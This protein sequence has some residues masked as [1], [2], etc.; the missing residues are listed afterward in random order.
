MNSKHILSQ[1][2]DSTLYKLYHPDTISYY[3][4]LY[5]DSTFNDLEY[6]L[7]SIFDVNNNKIDT[8][9]TYPNSAFSIPDSSF[10]SNAQDDV[11]KI[12]K[13]NKKKSFLEN[14]IKNQSSDS[15]VNDLINK[16]I[17][18]YNN[19]VIDY[20]NL[21]IESG[22]AEID[23]NEMTLFTR[24]YYDDEGKLVQKP[25]FKD[26]DQE[27][28]AETI[29]YNFDTGKGY[30]T[31]IITQQ[32]DGFLHGEQVKLLEDDITLIRHGGYTTC[33]QEHPHFQFKFNK[34]K[35]IP[36]DKI[37]SGLTYLE[38][39]GI[40]TPLGLP[41]AIFPIIEGGTS[42]IVVPGYGN[43]ADRGFFLENG[44]YYWYIN[45][46]IDLKLVGDIYSRGSWAIKPSIN[47]NKRYKYK[48]NFSFSY[49]NNKL[50]I[51][52]TKDFTSRNDFKITWKHNQD[53]K[54][55]PNNNFSAD[56]NFFTSSYNKYNPATTTDY[57]SS[58]F[59]SS[60][61]YQT[62][63]L[64]NKVNL[65]INL[66]HSQNTKTRSMTFTLPEFSLSVAKLYPFK[67]KVQVGNTRWYEKI[68]FNYSMAGKNEITSIDTLLLT[69]P[70][71][72]KMKNGIKHTLNASFNTNILKVLNFSVSANYN[73]RWYSKYAN[74]YY[75]QDTVYV[76]GEAI[77]PQLIVEELYKFKAARDFNFS[78][79]IGTTLYGMVQFKKGFL[80]AVRHVFTPS[81]SF[82]YTPD[83]GT[84]F[85][86]NYDYY[87][88]KNGDSVKYSIYNVSSFSSLY[89]SPSD[90]TSGR[91]NFALGNNLE[92]KVRSKNDTIT[93]TKKI[94]LIENLTISTYYDFAKDSLRLA[95][96]T[97]SGRT[98]IIK[99]L[100]IS[101]STQLSPYK[102]NEDGVTINEFIWKTEKRLFAPPSQSWN[103]GFSYTLN[104]N[105]FKKKNNNS[106]QQ[107]NDSPPEIDPIFY[108]SF[109]YIDWD[110]P[111]SISLNYNFRYEIRNIMV[112]GEYEKQTTL[113]NAIS[114]TG[115][116]NITPKWKISYNLTY[117]LKA[118]ELTY[119][120]LSIYRDLHCWEMSFNW[121]PFGGQKSWSFTINVKSSMLNSLKYEMKSE[122]YRNY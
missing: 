62:S 17:Y 121:I 13:Q 84:P 57:L 58:T 86:G 25:K 3:K 5:P 42:G 69:E 29:K 72:D 67:R 60:I 61:A 104:Q 27:F 79:S 109:E 90:G 19:F 18:Y 48:G 46:R 80:R 110:N 112:N 4:S 35:V 88:D 98:S 120:K 59:K 8:L 76:D 65:A 9:I 102:V 43:S 50:G 7:D 38:I 47:Y 85:W 44:G 66:G 15:M 113:V 105:T 10:L 114:C 115:N 116:V 23:M 83:F 21:H 20:G 97:I 26:G 117:D 53:A 51:K 40:P 77:P 2:I 118:L 103:L 37:V 78:T 12:I 45:D 89:G 56:V 107:Q 95:P 96:L 99:G 24:G 36:D 14:I 119:A 30:V 41:F 64:K 34:G 100:N 16:K 31:N 101:Y 32:G 22:Y 82:T 73:E 75:Q 111:W 70:I 11:N 106:I 6:L 87:E 54:A 91:I 39:E 94:K 1:N 28:I 49:A 55:R 68:S 71:L 52:G 108:N 122:D 63:F 81:I 92:I 93:G 74:A 33:D